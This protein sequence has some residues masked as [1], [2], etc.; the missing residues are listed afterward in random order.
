MADRLAPPELGDAELSLTPLGPEHTDLILRWRAR[1]EVAAELFSARPPTREEHERWLRDLAA[2]GDRVEL[3]IH[4][5]GRP[6]GTIGLSGIDLAAGVAEYGVL[7]GE[8]E[9]RGRGVA[10]RASMLLLDYAF[11]ELALARVRLELFRDNLSARR[12]YDRLGFVEDPVA[13]PPRAKGGR[14]RA[15][16]SMTLER[17]AWREH[18]ARVGHR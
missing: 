14:M 6:V 9:E 5:Q 11:G 18:R 12:L 1:P 8:P 13:P 17:L 15:T 4:H 7:L 10:A 16:T 3:V 2:R